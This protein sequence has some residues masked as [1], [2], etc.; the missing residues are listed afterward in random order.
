MTLSHY[1]LILEVTRTSLSYCVHDIIY[2]FYIAHIYIYICQDHH[3]I[4]V[5]YWPSLFLEN[6]ATHNLWWLEKE[7]NIQT[8]KNAVLKVKFINFETYFVCWKQQWSQYNSNVLFR[9]LYQRTYGAEAN[10]IYLLSFICFTSL[11]VIRG[12]IANLLLCIYFSSYLCL[13]VN[14]FFC[15]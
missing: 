1:Y 8:G 10:F 4:T 15:S 7:F 11:Q 5:A 2:K 3:R 14:E 9:Q 6:I 12:N 13:C